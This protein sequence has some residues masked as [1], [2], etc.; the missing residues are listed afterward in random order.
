MADALGK[1]VLKI[2]CIHGYRQNTNTCREKLGAFRKCVKKLPLEFVYTTAPNRIPR[3]ITGE[4][5][6]PEENECG[7]WF[8][9]PDDSYDPLAP[10]ELCKGFEDSLELIKKTFKEQGPFDGVFGFSQGASFL[11]IIC[12]LRDQGL[13]HFDFA[14]LVASFKSR[15][16]AH[17]VYYQKPIT[18]PTLHV[19]GDTDKVIPK[20][21]S[22]ELAKLFVDPVI[23]NHAG[24]HFVPASSAQKKVYLE[25]LEKFVS[26]K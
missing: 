3:T 12:A 15:S 26:A 16:S 14:I 18:C 22:E 1:K 6:S 9:S 7:W 24:G 17:D 8:S 4:I 23:L 5:A 25:F 19:Y 20:E 10:T 21:N 2:L 13:F 11:S